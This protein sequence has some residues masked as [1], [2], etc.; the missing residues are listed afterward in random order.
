MNK[1]LTLLLSLVLSFTALIAQDQT[2]SFVEVKTSEKDAATK[3]FLEKETQSIAGTIL[4]NNADKTVTIKHEGSERVFTLLGDSNPSD[5][6]KNVF[7]LKENKRPFLLAE[8]SD[9]L[10]L[11]GA[12]ERIDYA[13]KRE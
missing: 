7:Y 4:V 9:R 12:G 13:L 10:S 2:Y 6:Y 5:R 3:E 8:S 11:V 1:K